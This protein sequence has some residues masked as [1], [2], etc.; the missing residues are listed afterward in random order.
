MTFLG[1]DFTF[2]LNDILKFTVVL[3]LFQIFHWRKQQQQQQQHKN[4]REKT[5]WKWM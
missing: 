5:V 4:T 2:K 3:G 1:L